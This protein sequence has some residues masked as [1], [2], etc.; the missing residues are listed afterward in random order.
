MRTRVAA[1]ISAIVVSVVLAGCGPDGAVAPETTPAVVAPAVT[2]QQV[3]DGLVVAN[4]AEAL[5]PM[6]VGLSEIAYGPGNCAYNATARRFNCDVTK[7]GSLTL[8][9]SFTLLDASGASTPT[10]DPARTV[11]VRA[12]LLVAGAY[13]F[14]GDDLVIEGSREL[15]LSVSVPRTLNGTSRVHLG[16]TRDGSPFDLTVTTTFADIVVTSATGLAGWPVSGSIT[17]ESTYAPG[18]G[19]A[20]VVY[21]SRMSFSGSSTV[22]LAM[23]TDGTTRNCSVDLSR[24]L[25]VACA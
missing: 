15:T 16:G 4:L 8:T 6:P 22:A 10:F 1:R 19:S 3:L 2:L 18:A 14:E 23:F 5:M 11:S 12:S 9:P 24:A 20:P 21:R 17:V 7:F 13:R 25:I